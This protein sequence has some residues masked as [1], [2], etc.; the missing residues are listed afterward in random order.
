MVDRVVEGDL[1]DIPDIDERLQAVLLTALKEAKQKLEA[2]EE[3]VPFTALAV[4]D[5]LF[6]ETHPGDSSEEYYAAARHTVQHVRGAD[7]YAFCY[8]GYVETDEGTED[9]LIAEGGLSGEDEGVA[10]GFFYQMPEDEAG[11]PVVNDE[12]IYIGPAPNFM[13]FLVDSNEDDTGEDDPDTF[14]D[15]DDEVESSRE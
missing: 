6:L 1:N 9:V 13:A 8:D 5:N 12:P 2:G 15:F 3:V 4:K 10:I 14:D 7:A 11:I